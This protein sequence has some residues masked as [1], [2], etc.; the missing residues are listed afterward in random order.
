MKWLSD[1]H[2]IFNQPHEINRPSEYYVCVYIIILKCFDGRKTKINCLESLMML[3]MCY[4]SLNVIVY[5][6]SYL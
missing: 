1:L 2:I 5:I 3:E 6:S 4:D